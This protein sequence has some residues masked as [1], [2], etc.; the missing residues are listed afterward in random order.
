MD[1]LPQEM[2]LCIC[3]HC[4][5]S[6]LKKVRLVSRCMA[7]AA[8]PW[9]FEEIWIAFFPDS[10]EKLRSIAFHPVISKYVKSLICLGEML[11]AYTTMEQW[12]KQVELRPKQGDWMR[13]NHPECFDPEHWHEPRYTEENLTR[14]YDAIPRHQLSIEQQ[15]YHFMRYQYYLHQQGWLCYSG[16]GFELLR[17]SLVRLKALEIVQ[18]T[19]TPDCEVNAKPI[20]R[21]LKPEILVG[22][23][24]HSKGRLPA[25]AY[26]NGVLQLTTILWACSASHQPVKSIDVG[27]LEPEFWDQLMTAEDCIYEGDVLRVTYAFEHLSSLALNLDYDWVEIDQTRR[28]LRGLGKVTEWAK[29]VE[30]LDIRVRE[31]LEDPIQLFDFLEYIVESPLPRLRDLTLCLPTRE[32]SLMRLLSNVS[33][34]LRSLSLTK[35]GLLLDDGGTWRSVIKELPHT[36]TLHEIYLD[37]LG[38]SEFGGEDNYFKR[39]MVF[40]FEE[41]AEYEKRIY[42]YILHGGE[43]PDLTTPI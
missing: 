27:I 12:E 25:R 26:P 3:S 9:L 13:A 37:S 6:S 1:G 23:N 14:E 43:F 30:K 38:D 15:K 17:T 4:D 7:S 21:C 16:S 35:V 20:W 19:S 34:T 40:K 41:T 2:L 39:L 29:R 5:I 31:E 11:E 24:D 8:T 22:P 36:L 42:H 33:S 28:L 32:R 18:I 10:L